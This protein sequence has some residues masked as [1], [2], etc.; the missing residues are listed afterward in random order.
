MRIGIVGNPENRRVKDF[1]SASLRLGKETPLCLSWI[2]LLNDSANVIRKLESECDLVRLESPGENERVQQMLIRRGGI[3][4]AIEFGEIAYQREQFLGWRKTL[5][6][7][8]SLNTRFMIHPTEIQAMSDKWTSHQRFVA[9][10]LARPNAKLAPSNTERFRDFRNEFRTDMRT[11]AGRVFLKPRYGSSASGVCA[12][13]W[14]KNREMLIAP[15][16]VQN[17]GDKVRLF[18]SLKIRQYTDSSM[19]KSILGQLLP[20]EMVCERW[21]P[22][23]RVSDV[24][25]DLRILVVRGTARHVVVRQSQHP[26][27]NLHLGNKRGKL[28]DVLVRFGDATVTECR[29]LAEKATACFPDSLYAGVDIILDTKGKAYVCE[30]NAFGD[31][32]PNLY[33]REETA[34]E[35]IL[36]QTNEHMMSRVRTKS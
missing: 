32:L 15:I 7:L 6:Q 5:I 33:D 14:S 20:Q 12:Y 2:E 16:E 23:A 36:H 8:E 29:G 27:T 19:I 24:R 17:T 31:L 3:D 9:H 13:R 11:P 34:Y 30:I 18:N 28:S 35:A 22:K 10:G 21:I 1:Q 26:M 4:R 25:F